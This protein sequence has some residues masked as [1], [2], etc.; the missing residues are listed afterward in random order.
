MLKSILMFTSEKHVLR[1]FT[2]K[3]NYLEQYNIVFMLHKGSKK[4]TNFQTFMYFIYH[5]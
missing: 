1:Y 4:L 5:F 2:V 3:L